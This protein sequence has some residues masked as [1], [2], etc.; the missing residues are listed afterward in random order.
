M[1]NRE[2]TK[3]VEQPKEKVVVQEVEVNLALINEKL[4]YIINKLEQ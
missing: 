3:T 2:E 1:V 4:K